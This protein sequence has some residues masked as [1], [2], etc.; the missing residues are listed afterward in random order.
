M[1][2]AAPQGRDPFPGSN[3]WLCKLVMGTW[4]VAS[5]VGKEL[6]LVEEVEQFQVDIVGLTSTH[7][8][9]SVTQVFER[10][11][12]FFFGVA[13]GERWW[14][15]LDFFDSHHDFCSVDDWV[16]SLPTGNGCWLLSM[17][18]HR[19]FGCV[20]RV[21]GHFKSECALYRSAIVD[22]CCCCEL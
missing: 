14:A 16:A 2:R 15:R 20:R 4:N 19:P 21:E 13:V 3:A 1:D 12:T 7:S 5:L 9:C 6:E 18:M 11:W 17:L 22:C 10:G 8:L